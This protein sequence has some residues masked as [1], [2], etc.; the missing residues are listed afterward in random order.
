MKLRIAGSRTIGLP[1]YVDIGQ[2]SSPVVDVTGFTI[3]RSIANPQLRPRRADNLDLSLE[4][5][6]DRDSQLSVALFHKRIGD[7]IVRLTST[8][9]QHNPG[10][11]V[12]TYQVTTTQA[13]NA[14]DAQVQ[15]IEIT[16]IDTRFDFL[17]GAWAHLG[18]M[19]NATLLDP[20]TADVQMAD[21][22]RRALPGLMESPKRRANASLLYDI[23]P[24]S[25]RVSANY[26]GA[27]LLS[28][29]TDN[30]VNDRYYDAI[31]SYDAQLAWR[32]SPQLRLTVQGRNLSNARLTRVIGADQQLL[33]EQLDNGRAYY[34][35][36]DYAF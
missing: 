11:L 26:T 24:F 31:T 18:A 17:P 34:L 5:Y 9:V 29:A 16:A 36:V 3:N 1:T 20:R 25:A 32:F 7:E 23:G 27:Q 10:G 21:G 2:N 14:G 28:A 8:D 33:R 15:G 22:T 13:I 35:G 19:F 4:W 30:R 12:G 6:P